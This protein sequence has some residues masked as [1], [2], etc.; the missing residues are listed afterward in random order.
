MPDA[1]KIPA[2]SPATAPPAVDVPKAAVL[3]IARELA[4]EIQPGR[5]AVERAGLDSSLD[6]DWGFD[7]LSRAELLLRIER[8]FATRL[9][10]RLLG[11][12]ETL[13]DLLD[14]LADAKAAPFSFPDVAPRAPAAEP[15]EP[16][17]DTAATLTE[18]LDWHVQRHGD[19]VHI[20][21]VEGDGGESS[22]TYRQLGERARTVAL[23]LNRRGLEPGERVAIMLPTCAEYFTASTA[24]CCRRRPGAALSAGAPVQIE[25]HCAPRRHPA[26]LRA[27]RAGHRPGGRPRGV[28]AAARRCERCAQVLVGDLA[29]GHGGAAAV[30][31]PV[32]D[33]DMRFIQ[34]TSGSTGKPKGVVLTHAN[35]LA[36]MRAMGAGDARATRATCS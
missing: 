21:L 22:I 35:L 18:V 25:D 26:Q 12:A 4:R 3:R 13:R 6:E 32:H 29:D 20:V 7:S 10:E 11:E 1:A 23:G 5:R 31:A 34:Y 2:V 30:P 24:R 17:P 9:P 28:A 16:A 19:R 33:A 8:A 36:N 27:R 14:A 15:A